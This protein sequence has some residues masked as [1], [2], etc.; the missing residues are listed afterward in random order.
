VDGL[1]REFTILD[2]TNF[3]IENSGRRGPVIFIFTDTFKLEADIFKILENIM[4]SV[5]LKDKT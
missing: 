4:G 3:T 5:L 1:K 2:H